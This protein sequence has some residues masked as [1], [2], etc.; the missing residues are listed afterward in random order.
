MEL[1]IAIYNGVSLHFQPESGSTLKG[2]V[3]KVFRSHVGCLI[4]STFNASI[5]KQCRDGQSLLE[6][7]LQT[8]QEILFKVVKVSAQN[9][10]LSMIGCFFD[11]RWACYILTMHNI[12]GVKI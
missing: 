7:D 9:G 6:T 1:N 4:H 12:S 11:E 3:N 2:V 5:P 10:V 8:G